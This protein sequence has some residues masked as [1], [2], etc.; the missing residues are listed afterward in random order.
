MESVLDWGVDVVLWLQRFSPRL[1]VLFRVFTFLGDE[2]FFLLLLPLVYWSLNRVVGVRL[3][4]LFLLSGLMNQA[5]KNLAAQPRPFTY[6]LRVKQI[7]F[8]SSYGFPSGHTQSAVVVWGYLATVVRRRW[9]WALAAILTVGVPL[10]R[11]Y[12]GVHFP[13]DVLGGYLLGFVVL[14]LWSAYAPRLERRFLALPTARQLIVILALPALAMAVWPTEGMVTGGAT[15]VGI[16]SGLV[17]ERR[18][19]GFEVAGRPLQRTL[20]Y[21]LGAAV[22]AGLWL[23]LR[24]AFAGLEPAVL[25]RLVRYSIVGFWGAFGAPWAF[26]RIGLAGREED[27]VRRPITW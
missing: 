26:V 16:G 27:F 25:F 10:S 5:A 6:D 20:R 18:L 2:E 17:L 3:M 24:Y 21:L 11:I 15:M 23:G 22:L 14:V 9:F 13:T 12:L 1:D 4:V 8:E 19:V 7:G